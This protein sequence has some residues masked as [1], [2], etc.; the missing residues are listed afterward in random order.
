MPSGGARVGAGRKSGEAWK[1][2]KPPK[3]K[4][5]IG[6]AGPI[7]KKRRLENASFVYV[8]GEDKD[9]AVFKFGVARDP[10]DRLAAL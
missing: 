1:S 7:T 10:E 5:P 6:I 8:I 3:P 2:S 9:P 4:R